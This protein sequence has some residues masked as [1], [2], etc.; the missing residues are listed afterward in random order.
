MRLR[1]QALTVALAA[2]CLCGGGCA[3]LLGSILA[4]QAAAMSAA[5]GVADTVLAPSRSELVGLTSEVDRLLSG[6]AADAGE[7]QRI[8]EELGR[9]LQEPGRGDAAQDE[10]ERLRPWHA[11]APA[12]GR[13][14]TDKQPADEMI[15]G[16]PTAERGLVK[17]GPLPDG[18]PAGDLQA[19]LDLSQI[20][21]RQR[22]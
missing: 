8:K 7:L 12:E 11:R 1:H 14:L 20:R 9:R 13:Q 18:I 19:P 4:P 15:V 17:H 10:P 2:A 21:Y 3:R 6:R 16:R 5:G 22:R